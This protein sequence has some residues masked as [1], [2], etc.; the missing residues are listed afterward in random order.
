[1]SFTARCP[2]YE[3]YVYIYGLPSEIQ[4]SMLHLLQ[5]RAQ[6]SR[7]PGRIYDTGRSDL[8]QIKVT[9]EAMQ[10]QLLQLSGEQMSYLS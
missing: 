5:R 1:M 9:D 4:E 2:I 7:L 8:A 3:L 10:R 6:L